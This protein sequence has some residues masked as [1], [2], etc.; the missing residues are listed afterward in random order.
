M[1][2]Q[3]STQRKLSKATIETILNDLYASSPNF[4][5][6]ANL[7]YF[8]PIGAHSSGMLGENPNNMPNNIFPCILQVAMNK[9]KVLN[10]YGDDWNTIDG[11]GVRDYIH[12]LD[13]AEAHMSAIKMLLSSDP[14]IANINIGTGKA[15]SVLQF[16]KSLKIFFF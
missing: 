7:R 3:K 12:V 14:K 11:T 2:L 15:T 9:R 1:S 8:N 16:L 13:L 5:K 4:W 10:I 6:L